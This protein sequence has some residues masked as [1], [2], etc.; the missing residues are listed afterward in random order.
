LQETAIQAKQLNEKEVETETVEKLISE[1]KKELL[2]QAYKV[3]GKNKYISKMQQECFY[4]TETLKNYKE[5]FNDPSKAEA[6]AMELLGQIPAVKTF[7]QNNSMLAGLFGNPSP[8]GGVGGGSASLAGLQTRASVNNLI[9]GRIAA[10]GP[11]A[12]AQI[13]QNIQAAQSELTKLKDKLI[14]STSGGG[15]GEVEEDGLPS[16]KKSEVKSK[17]FKQRLEIGSNFQFGKPNRFVSSQADVAMS[18][19]YKLNDKSLV[20]IGLSYKLN[21][22]SVS[23]FYVQHGGVGLRS[24]VDWKISSQRGGTKG[25]GF[26]LSGGYE[27]NYN[28]SFKNFA[29]LQNANGTTGIGNS[30]LSSGL[31][32]ISKKISFSPTSGGTKGGKTKWVKGTK[33]SLLYDFL[34]NS[35]VVPTQPVVFR[36]GYNF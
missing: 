7:V 3:L 11:N 12:A 33:L 20:G 25:G 15:R 6:K 21:Y 14:R 1:R 9:Q 28:N 35:H 24:F 23:N 16:F 4:Y 32:G 5:I 18:V 31:I 2:T 34:Y 29:D 27:T 13:S 17:T 36:V 26:F 22:G 30:W 10:G 19:G 8:F